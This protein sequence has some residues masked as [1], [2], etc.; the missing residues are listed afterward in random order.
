MET[1]A[2]S[3]WGLQRLGHEAD[4]SLS[5]TVEVKST[6]RCAS[7]APL[8]TFIAWWTRKTFTA[9]SALVKADGF[10]NDKDDEQKTELRFG[11]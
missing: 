8:Y 2:I 10:S 1:G 3:F 5:S 6:W 4:H 7:A 11:A 9:P